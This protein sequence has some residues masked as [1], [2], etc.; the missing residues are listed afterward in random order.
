[1]RI[2]QRGLA[3]REN[4]KNEGVRMV[5]ILRRIVLEAGRRLT[6]RGLL[7]TPEDALFLTLDELEPAL[8]DPPGFDVKAAVKERKETH[9]RWQA[10][11][12][13]PVIV[14]EWRP[15]TSRP[16]SPAP[17]PKTLHGLAVSP[18]IVTGKARVILQA[19]TSERL[20][21]SEILVAPYTDPGWTPY[22]LAASAV[23]VDVGGLLSHGS[24]VAREYGLPAVV[25][26]GHA[27][28]LVKTGQTIE[29]DG[30]RGVVTI[31]D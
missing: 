11:H 22:F 12:P 31:L 5:S 1:V 13:P 3:Q 27:T 18:G 9:G 24:V 15:E 10:L 4:V 30:Y 25:N 16:E 28:R 20:L 19:D 21:G 8:R 23:V 29:V 7:R 17:E 2:S 26:V 14:G 6:S